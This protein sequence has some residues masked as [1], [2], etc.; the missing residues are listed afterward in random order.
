MNT[1]Y[2]D[3]LSSLVCSEAVVLCKQMVSTAA[4]LDGGTFLENYLA[5]IAVIR[6]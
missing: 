3:R 4:L 6:F 1:V 2:Y 5:N